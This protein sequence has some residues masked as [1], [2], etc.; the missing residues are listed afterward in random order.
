MRDLRDF[1]SCDPHHVHVE[2]VV[3]TETIGHSGKTQRH[4]YLGA[5]SAG[6]FLLI[7]LVSPGSRHSTAGT[8]RLQVDLCTKRRL[9][10]HP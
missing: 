10:L 6:R 3:F 7:D 1:L 4:S 9:G 8:G 5:T 2:K